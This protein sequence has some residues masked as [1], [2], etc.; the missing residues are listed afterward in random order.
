MGVAWDLERIDTPALTVDLDIMERNLERAQESATRQG[1]ALWPHTKTHKV[2]E[3]A[4]RQLALGAGGL[5]VAKLGEAE[6][7]F[8]AGLS[9]LSIHYPLVGEPKARRLAALLER[10]AVVRVVLDGPEAADTVSRAAGW[11]GAVVDILVEIDPGM[12]RVGVAPGGAAVALARHVASRPG[13]RLRGLASY[14]GHISGAAD[15]A[16]RLA[17]LHREAEAIAG[18]REL[19][20][21]EGLAPEVVSVGGSHHGARMDRL[22]GATE[23]RPGTYIYNDRNILAAGSCTEADLAA[24]VVVTVVSVQG[25]RAVI[26][27]GSKAF[28]SDPSPLGGFGLFVGHPGWS[29]VRM[30]E[31]HGVI[32]WPAADRAPGVGQ[33]LCVV[34]NHICA[35]VN[36]YDEILGMRGGLVE[37]VYAVAGRGRSR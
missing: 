35:T 9:P 31:E 2:A 37:R 36:L 6:V 7:L 24:Q 27:G 5:T 4:R 33:R 15:E 28:S 8:A 23:V 16:G 19:L 29:L 18:T 25:D 10:G 11:A 1:L 3:F 21:R 34:P 12:H 13:L 26:D 22:A 30:N 14:A 20:E 32:A 17:I